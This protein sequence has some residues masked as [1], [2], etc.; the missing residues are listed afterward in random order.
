MKP[1]CFFLM[2]LYFSVSAV[3]FGQTDRDDLSIKE[4]AERDANDDLNKPLWF[5]GGLISAFA[6]LAGCIIAVQ[7]GE[8][9]FDIAPLVGSLDDAFNGCLIG[10]FVGL[11]PFALTYYNAGP[12]PKRLIGKPPEYIE[13]YTRFY[14]RKTK[15]LRQR[16]FGSGVATGCLGISLFALIL[17]N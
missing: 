8:D 13:H 1:F 16:W 10:S 12:S 11:L 2:M 3:A 17:D 14:Q 9:D 6:P 5:S 4:V 7:T 15:A